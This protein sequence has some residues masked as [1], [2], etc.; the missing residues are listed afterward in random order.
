MRQ[1]ITD[2]SIQCKFSIL[3]FFLSLLLILQ[4]GHTRELELEPN[5]FYSMI[6]RA[7]DPPIFGKKEKPFAS[8][9]CI[10]VVRDLVR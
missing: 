5:M 1:S 4:V 7:L 6:T 9:L 8:S 2:P 3:A 10:L